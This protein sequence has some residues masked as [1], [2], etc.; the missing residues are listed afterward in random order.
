MVRL[1]GRSARRLLL[2]AV[3]SIAMAA[4]GLAAATTATADTQP[5]HFVW[6]A[7][8]TSISTD[9]TTI[10]N[11]ATNNNPNA[12]LFV[13]S[14]WDANAVC[15]CV[16]DTAPLGVY[17]NGSQWGIFNEDGS[18]MPVGASFNVVVLP[19]A[20][21]TAF[22][23]AA[24]SG[25]TGGDSLFLGSSVANNSALFLQATPVWNGLFDTSP[26]GVYYT[27]SQFAIFNENQSSMAANLRFNVLV[28]AVGGGKTGTLTASKSNTTGDSMLFNNSTTNGDSNSFAIATPN[29]NPKAMCGCVYDANTL[30]VWFNGSNLAVFNETGA[31][32]ALKVSAN[33]LYWNS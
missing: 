21:S 4:G 11:G 13:T 2:P 3:V 26:I 30:G 27:G 9:L 14:N 17:Y 1:N 5:S 10:N 23:I 7:T 19:A 16:N 28:G 15:G 33:L 6:T 22:S 24:S 20:T 32:M 8:S 18:N 25:N 31:N 29:F 12:L